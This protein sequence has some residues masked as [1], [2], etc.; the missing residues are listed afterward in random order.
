MVCI[1]DSI[2]FWCIEFV[3]LVEPTLPFSVL[4]RAI[5]RKVKREGTA[6]RVLFSPDVASSFMAVV[7]GTKKC[8]IYGTE[9]FELVQDIPC[10]Q[11]CLLT[12]LAFDPSGTIMAIGGERQLVLSEG[13]GLVLIVR[14]GEL[15]RLDW[16]CR[17]GR[18]F[19]NP[20]L[21]CQ[22]LS[23]LSAVERAQ[24]LFHRTD[25]GE[26]VV[27]RGHFPLEQRIRNALV[28]KQKESNDA[29]LGSTIMNT[30]PPFDA[31]MTCLRAILAQFPQLVFAGVPGYGNTLFEVLL[32]RDNPRLLKLLFYV[33]LV[34]C[35]SYPYL[36]MNEEMR[37]GTVTR[38]L[39]ASCDAYP[40]GRS[41]SQQY[42][43]FHSN[44]FV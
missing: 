18:I 22:K 11:S 17:S 15:L 27:D 19:A 44:C 10:S 30:E 3:S 6:L 32:E 13:D 9:S 25:D 35:R 38:A 23:S 1:N 5:K 24:I 31:L 36:A 41:S 40:E 16:Y 37:N 21:L 12:S 14:V 28:A 7:G 2:S 4:D 43:F 8:S 42:V 20:E 33:A 26:E 29:M 34:T 39:I